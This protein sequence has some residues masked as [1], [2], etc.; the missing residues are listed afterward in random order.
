MPYFEDSLI[1]LNGEIKT[2]QIARIYD[3][4]R[5]Y[6]GSFKNNPSQYYT[7]NANKVKWLK[8]PLCWPRNVV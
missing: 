2:T 8:N 5:I 1:I 7:Y 4:G 6:K 3:N